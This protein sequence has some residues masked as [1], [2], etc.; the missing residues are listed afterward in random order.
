[1]ES[2]WFIVDVDGDVVVS[3]PDSSGSYFYVCVITLSLNTAHLDAPNLVFV[4]LFNLKTENK[5][6]DSLAMTKGDTPKAKTRFSSHSVV[7]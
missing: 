4:D 2:R 7:F 1:M 5:G 6:N 3:F